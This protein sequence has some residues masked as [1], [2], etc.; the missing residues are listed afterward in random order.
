[1]LLSQKLS[2]STVSLR[3]QSRSSDAQPL[4]LEMA[5]STAAHTRFVR[6]SLGIVTLGWVFGSVWMNSTSGAPLTLFA[7]GLGATPFQFGLLSALPFIASLVSMPASL[8][9][10]RTGQRKSIFLRGLYTQRLMWFVIALAP[11]LMVSW[12]G[13]AAAPRAM[14]MVLTLMFLMHAAGAFGAPAWVSWMADVV[15]ERL[16]G[17]YFS[18]RRQ[19]GIM[20]AIPAALIV[21]WVL[22]HGAAGAAGGSTAALWVCAGVFA[23]AAVF[24][25]VDIHVFR[26]L[27]ETPKPPHKGLELLTALEEPLKNKRF[28]SFAGFVATLTFAV[29]FMGQFVTLYLIEKVHVGNTGTQLMLLVAPMLAQLVVLPVWGKAC[30]RMGKKP[31]L[32]VAALGLVPVGMGWCLVTESHP[33]LG[34]VMSAAGTA[35][36]TGVEMANFNLVLEMSSAHDG[37]KGGGSSYVAVNSVIINIAGCLGGF[38]AGFISQGLAGWSWQPLTGMKAFTF[39][40]VL[41]ALSGFLR[42]VAVVVF[43]PF[44]HEPTARGSTEALRFMCANIYNNL[45][46]ALLQP[47][48]CVAVRH[49]RREEAPEP[50]PAEVCE[51]RA[52]A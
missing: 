19:C 22:D 26:Y 48:R 25:F 13:S 32:V 51:L 27:P 28:L 14:A 49:H 12:Y 52:A 31:V 11:V 5:D 33:W 9:I 36:W 35:L 23:V 47:I 39:Y 15:P 1:M 3:L 45:H 29:S 17:K 21:G 38:A 10:E 44:V 34:Y 46:H 8:L 42:L 30:D 50:E 43:L 4:P 6:R 16:R 24:G 20:S 41:F 2:S 7:K 18:R 37:G 40:D